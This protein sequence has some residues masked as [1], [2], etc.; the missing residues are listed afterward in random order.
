[1]ND[2]D[3]CKL[4]YYT[5]TLFISIKDSQTDLLAAGV[6]QHILGAEPQ[7]YIKWG[8]NTSSARYYKAC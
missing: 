8:S 1:M 4:L 6:L 7:G 2:S 3:I 5:W